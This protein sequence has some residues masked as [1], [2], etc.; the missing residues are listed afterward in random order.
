MNQLVELGIGLVSLVA[1]IAGSE[2]LVSH[3]SALM[4]EKQISGTFIGLVVISI[5]TSLPEIVAHI[6]A[7]AEII[8]GDLN[9]NVASGTTLGMNI[10]SDII[11]QNLLIGLVALFGSLEVTD[12]FVRRDLAMLI[13]AAAAV[14]IFGYAGVL[15]RWEGGLLAAGYLV[16]LAFVF[17]D[18]RENPRSPVSERRG[19]PRTRQVSRAKWIHWAWIFGG[20]AVILTGGH[21][22]LNSVQYF[23]ESLGIGGS[24]IG[25]AVIGVGTALP[26]LST[27]VSG[28]RRGQSDLSISTLVGSNITNPLF[29][30]GIGALISTY[31]VPD[32]LVYYDL[33][34]KIATAFLIFAIFWRNRSISRPEGVILVASYFVYL[35]L[36]LYLFPSDL[37]V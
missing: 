23:V 1:L 10:G 30:I 22:A 21:F 35:G 28:I 11:Q 4:K 16:Y 12:T 33:P 5:G 15:T 36:R 17:R 29:A 2:K 9:Y 25:V 20:L 3:C 24:M 14:W 7:S 18:R 8:T 34:F 6:L 19:P 26:E 32:A 27:A 31:S 13:G 37:F